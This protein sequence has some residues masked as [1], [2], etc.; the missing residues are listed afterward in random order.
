MKI[1]TNILKY[2]LRNV[3]FITGTAYAGK[4]TM[5]KMLAEKFDMVFCGENYFTEVTDIVADPAIQPDLCYIKSLTDFKDFVTRSP[6][7]YNRW[8]YGVGREAAGF[9]IAE[10][11]SLSRDKKVIVDTNI[12]LDVL[13]EISDY[14]HV[15]IMLSPQSMSVERF[16][17]RSDPEKQFI[18]SVID[19]CE[20][21]E[22]VMENYRKGLAL[23]NSKEHYEEM[24]NSGFFTLVRENTDED[25]REE[26]CEKLAK[27][28]GLMPDRTINEI[29]N[30]L[31]TELYDNGYEYGFVVNKQKYKPNMEN[32]FDKEYYHLSTTIYCVQD[33][34]TTMKEKIG[35]CVDAVL[36]MRWLL[37]KHNISSKIWLLHNHKKNKVH[38]ILTFEAENKTVYLE[39]TPQSSKPWYGKEIIY[40][41]EQE[42]IL[43]YETNGY[44]I[45]DVTDF[46][47][48]GQQPEF[49]LAKLQ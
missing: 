43:E 4:S 20:N 46:I 38:T 49:L 14:N 12:P 36:V 48:I 7:E 33:P 42:L 39:L 30:V 6:E 10:L 13:K 47:V 45:S 26:V 9:E 37:N 34:I 23:I 19:S 17:D 35:T 32:G 15:A 40:S 29:C 5:V 31:R 16:F 3:Y 8:I 18:L 27:H 11:I 1:E 44:D 2:Y 28:F 41:N 24:A 25:T 21:S 22:K